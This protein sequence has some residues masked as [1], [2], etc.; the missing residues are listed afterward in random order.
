MSNNNELYNS[1]N[2]VKIKKRKTNRVLD[3]K[4]EINNHKHCSKCL[5]LEKPEDQNK[6]DKIK[7]I[8]NRRINVSKSYKNFYYNNISKDNKNDENEKKDKINLM[9]Q[10]I[11]FVPRINRHK[12]N[13]EKFININMNKE[14]DEIKKNQNQT[15]YQK[16]S[17]TINKSY[18]NFNT[19]YK[20]KKS[21]FSTEENNRNNSNNKYMNENNEEPDMFYKR[22]RQNS[23]KIIPEERITNVSYSLKTP[24]YVCNN[25]FD[26]EMLEGQMPSLSNSVINSKELLA[27]KFINENPFYFIDKMKDIEKKRIQNK[28]DNLTQKQRSVLP[29]YEK[30]INKPKNLKKEKLQLINEYS[31]NPLAIEHNKDPKFLQLKVFFDQKEKIIQNNPD[32]YPGLVPRKALQDY[33]EKCMYQIPNS[34]EV[35]T[36]NPVYKKNYIKVL[37]QQIDDK[38]REEKN[39]LKKTKTAEFLANEQF[40]EYKKQEKLNELR[41]SRYNLQLLNKDNKKLDNYK[42]IQE[43]KKQK[44]E[45]KFVKKLNLLKDRENKEY[46]I[47]YK[48][49][50]FMDYEL[51]QKM[52]DDMNRKFI[53]NIHNKK[54]ENRKWNNYLDKYIMRYG[55][56]NRYNNCDRCNRPIQNSHQ[57]KQYP[58]SKS[59][60]VNV[61]D[62]Y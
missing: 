60:C 47:R 8:D 23:I 11:N 3:K 39:Y 38:A 51:Y 44:E 36:I 34:E 22:M 6:N 28:I 4:Q 18:S 27:E 32:I 61:N 24:K 1:Y 35:Y 56:K 12:R 55:Y 15:Q 16:H 45:E 13:L 54:E 37:K 43:E 30:E 48:K 25:C 20:R 2:Y 57:L 46:K 42:K 19:F 33:Y 31:L 59:D 7:T 40:N 50:K 26:K 17:I 10:K 58:P 49:E 9:Y 29:I 5:T 21:Y 14:E 53:M 41:K 62:N 52:F